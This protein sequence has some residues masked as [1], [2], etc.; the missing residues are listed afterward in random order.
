MRKVRIVVPV[1]TMSCQVVEKWNTGPKTAQS[2]MSEKATTNAH[3]D[4]VTPLV[5]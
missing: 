3:G 2:T 4:P 5:Q 1:F